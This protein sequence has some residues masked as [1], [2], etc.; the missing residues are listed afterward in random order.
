VLGR[1]HGWRNLGRLTGI[2]A[3]FLQR[4]STGAKPISAKSAQA[5][6]AFV[7]QPT[8]PLSLADVA[9]GAAAG[10]PNMYV[11]PDMPL[12]PSTPPD[13]AEGPDPVG[14][15]REELELLAAWTKADLVAARANAMTAPAVKS[16]LGATLQRTLKELRS[17]R[18]EGELTEATVARSAPGRRVITAIVDALA[19]FPAALRAARDAL[20]KLTDT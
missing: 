13:D 16:Q 9:A 5:L 3:S 8:R 14:T 18:G 15:T 20:A 2:N 12:K 10:K 1:L 7:S 17:M 11:T 6:G 4:M 19:P